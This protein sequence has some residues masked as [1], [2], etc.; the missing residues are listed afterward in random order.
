MVNLG[1]ASVARSRSTWLR[2]T[3]AP[4]APTVIVVL[5]GTIAYL[6]ALRQD[7]SVEQV[8]HTHQVIGHTR[9]VLLRVYDAQAR[10][11]EYI[12][13]GD[14]SFLRRYATA[15]RDAHILLDE[16]RDLTRDNK[17]QQKRTDYLDHLLERQIAL[18]DGDIASRRPGGVDPQ[19]AAALA[20]G[21]LAQTYTDSLQWVL[22]G[23]ETAERRLLAARE[24]ALDVNQTRVLWIVGLGTLL[25]AAVGLLI[26][27]TLS[28]YARM[29]QAQ[30]DQLEQQAIQLEQLNDALLERT[31][32]AENANRSK[33]RFLAAMSHDLR[34]PLNAIMG[35]V[36][37]MEM[38]IHGTVSPEQ[39]GYLRRITRSS[40][41]L[42]SLINDVLSFAKIEAGHVE[43]DVKTLQAADVLLGLEA[44]V[45][46]QAAE[47]GLQLRYEKC[48][49]ALALLGDRKKVDQ[50]LIN[51]VSNAIKFTPRGGAI[52]ISC[53]FDA[54]NVHM[55]VADNGPG[56]AADHLESIFEP[57]VQL[58]GPSAP[59]GK[60]GFGLGLA[61]SREFARSMRGDLT[62]RSA[63]GEGSTFILTLPRS[64]QAALRPVA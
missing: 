39:L 11:R 41:H 2:N 40:E 6:T 7:R 23:I 43:L 44:I 61:I 46:P 22:G 50:I 8:Q 59:K 13:T 18:L 45:S 56:I 37:L 33:A 24:R 63:V 15:L 54:Q 32:D 25:A 16:L 27:L 26:N 48:D 58:E 47:K 52:T 9:D 34:T 17:N 19:R 21:A 53:S 29:L 42:L 5:F 55:S 14:T 30:T 20:S 49:P 36:D 1:M 10:E 3:A 62:V 4:F 28:N 35:Y 57:Y 38:G 60:H 12:L 51:L 31:E 64:R